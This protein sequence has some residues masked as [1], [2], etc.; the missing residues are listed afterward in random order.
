MKLIENHNTYSNTF[1][2]IAMMH[3]KLGHLRKG[4]QD[5]HFVRAVLSKHPMLSEGDLKEFLRSIHNKL[6]FPAM[7]LVS[8]S[9]EYSAENHD[10]KRKKFMGE[11]FILDRVKKDDFDDLE[12]KLDETEQTGEE[13]IAFLGDY[14]EEHPQDGLFIW[15]EGQSEKIS[16]LEVDNLAG[17]KFYFTIDVPHQAKLSNFSDAFYNEEA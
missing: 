2:N 12:V 10:A 11:F 7:V 5:I 14:Y 3:K 9:A 1:R 17:T 15:E 8:Y 13:I 6:R 4:E 16:N